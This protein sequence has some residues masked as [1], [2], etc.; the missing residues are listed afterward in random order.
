MKTKL[1]ELAKECPHC[2]GCGL[3]NPNGN[4]LCLAHSNSLADGRGAY[5]KSNDLY[6]AYL[7]HECHQKVDI[8]HGW[9]KPK[10]REFHNLAWIK[11]MRWWIDGGHVKPS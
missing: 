7:C 1:R 10:K 6:G 5:H 2:M 8:G 3:E 4:L 9:D 11:T